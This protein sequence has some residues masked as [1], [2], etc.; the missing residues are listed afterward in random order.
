MWRVFSFSF[1]L[2]VHLLIVL[3]RCRSYEK[4]KKKLMVLEAPNILTI[5]LKR[6]QVISYRKYGMLM[7]YFIFY[8]FFF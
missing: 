4:A 5:V 1:F 6:F 3:T 2:V 7:I 8:A